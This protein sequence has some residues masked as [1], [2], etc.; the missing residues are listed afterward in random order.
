MTLSCQ[1]VDFDLKIAEFR[2]NGY[3]VF[4]DMIAPEKVDAIRPAFLP[5]LANVQ[6]RETEVH[7]LGERGDPR[8]G[9]G[10]LQTTNRYTLTI[11]WL[12]P[13]ADPEIYEHPVI[14]EFLDRLW[15]PDGYILTCYH[16]NTPCHGSVFQHW[17]RDTNIGNDIPHVGLETVP[18]V[19]VKYPLCDTS[20]Q[21]G[22]FEVLPSTQYLALP[23]YEGHYD[24]ILGKGHFPSAHRLNL[25]KGAMWVQDVRTLHRGTPN[26]SP[27]PRPELCLCYGRNFWHIDQT[28]K[29]PESSYRA[30]S[31]RGKQLLKRYRPVVWD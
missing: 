28:I 21:N 31:A 3:T 29:M 4:D 26:P 7:D 18:I 20:E 11:P 17:H 23:E 12:A 24:E 1:D 2:I 8:T 22:S 9:M 25:N 5:L 14:L 15:K 27:D 19:G 13:F 6:E 10:R 30:L 16:S